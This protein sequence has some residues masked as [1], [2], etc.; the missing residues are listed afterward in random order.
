M[1][2]M[3]FDQLASTYCSRQKCEP[4]Q[5]REL[6]IAQRDKFNPDG[7]MLLECADMCSSHYSGYTILPFGPN[8]TYKTAQDKNAL[9]S[10]RGLASDASVVVGIM[11]KED[12]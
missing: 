12:L 8:N 7:W 3:T 4:Y 2:T 11:R 9:I 10:P 1:T 6:L 5:L